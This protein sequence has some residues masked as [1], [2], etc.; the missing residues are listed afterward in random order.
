MDLYED[1]EHKAQAQREAA[2]EAERRFCN[3]IISIA[4]TPDGLL[5]MRW[6]IGKSQILA[7][8]PS[9]LDPAQ[10]AYNEGKRHIGAQLIA[11]AK[12]AGVLPEILKED[13]NGY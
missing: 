2:L 11:L 13:T 1:A 4:A 6:L 3:A 9:P 12:K 7:A 8:Y 5:F 10:A